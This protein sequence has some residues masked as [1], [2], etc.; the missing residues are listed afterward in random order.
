MLFSPAFTEELIYKVNKISMLF[1][2]L[3]R[4]AHHVIVTIFSKIHI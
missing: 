2:G 4:S 3:G 1:C